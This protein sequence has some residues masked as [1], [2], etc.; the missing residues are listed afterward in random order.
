MRAPTTFRGLFRRAHPAQIAFALGL[1]RSDRR[2]PAGNVRTS[3]GTGP[4]QGGIGNPSGWA[5]WSIRFATTCCWNITGRAR[6]TDSSIDEEPERSFISPK[7]AGPDCSR[8]DE[9]ERVVR[10]ILGDL[11]ERDRRLLQSVLIEERDK[12][13]VCAELGLSRDYLRVLVH[14]AK[15]SF[16]SF[17]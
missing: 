4:R 6:S 8:C 3:T 11:P 7:S 13:E 1:Q 9:A 2:C 5:R 16:K 15:Q 17:T 14:R 12:D 10:K